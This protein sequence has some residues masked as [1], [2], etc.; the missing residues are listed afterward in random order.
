M[1]ISS[2]RVIAIVFAALAMGMHLAHA[3]ELSP[4]LQWPAELYLPVQTSLYVLFGRIGPA[5]EIG[6][7]LL[8]AWLA[9]R[10][11]DDASARLPTMTSAAMIALA[12]IVW[13]LVVMPANVQIEAWFKAG[14]TPADWARWRDQWQF[15][16]AGIF[17]LH[18]IG[19]TALVRGAVRA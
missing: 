11:R 5:L 9:F 16:Q 4:K 2:L 7:L 1:S 15:G 10:V 3:L 13:A 17:L 12:L 14:T 8:V 18:L 19:F 6:A